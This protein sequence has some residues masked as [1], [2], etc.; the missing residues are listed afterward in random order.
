[1]VGALGGRD[2]TELAAMAEET[3]LRL[4]DDPPNLF[5]EGPLTPALRLDYR[6]GL[7]VEG[8]HAPFPTASQTPEIAWLT[9]FAVPA[10]N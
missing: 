6:D 8:R 2:L 7:F 5:C 10:S 9:A 4:S 3:S 1:M